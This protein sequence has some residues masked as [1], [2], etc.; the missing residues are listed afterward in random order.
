[1]KIIFLNTGNAIKRF[2]KR[3]AIKIYVILLFILTFLLFKYPQYNEA[4]AIL[5]FLSGVSILAMYFN[6]KTYIELK[7]ESSKSNAKCELK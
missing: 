5:T 2:L 7:A 3:F 4:I 6:I 1:M